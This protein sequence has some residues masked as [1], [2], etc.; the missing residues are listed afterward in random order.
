MKKPAPATTPE[1]DT[2]S[3]TLRLE[4]MIVK[5]QRAN[6]LAKLGELEC[7]NEMAQQTIRQL[8]EQV[9]KFE[10]PAPA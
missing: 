4:L 6:L 1:P 10:K 7:A 8:L 9:A 3:A 5:Q 2:D